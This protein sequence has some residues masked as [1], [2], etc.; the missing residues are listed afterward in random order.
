MEFVTLEE[1]EFDVFAKCQ[2]H[3]NFWQSVDM[4]KLRQKNG[5][6]I[7]YIGVKEKQ[8][9]VAGAM[10]SYRNIFLHYMRVE[11]LRGAYLDYE[12]EHM[13]R[14][15]YQHMITYAKKLH[16]LYITV[17][18]YL[19]LQERDMFGKL[20]IDGFD[21]HNIINI[22]ASLG[23]C[24]RPSF[25]GNDT[26]KEPGWMFVREI[27]E[28][29]EDVLFASLDHQTR[30]SIRKTMKIGI[31][32]E[33]GTHDDVERF[34]KI[35][36]HTA[37]RRSFED[38]GFSYYQQLW[39][40]FGASHHMK[41]LFAKL[42][43]DDYQN[44]I[45][46]ELLQQQEALSTIEAVLQKQ[47]SSRKYN[48]RKKACFEQI[49]V[50]EKQ[51]IEANELQKQGLSIDLAAAIFITTGKEIVYLYSGAY[52]EYLKFNGPYAL[53][54]Y[55]FR[56]AIKNGYLRY[57]F[58]GI[59]G[60]FEKDAQDYGVYEFKRGF[61]GHVEELIGEFTY[62]V[63]PKTYHIYQKLRKLKQNLL[64]HTP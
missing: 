28:H 30:W 63:R 12:N 34:H 25:I 11:I 10:V 49:Q 40:T 26:K 61:G 38:R 24:Y 9:I 7:A 62:I 32:V 60:N 20:V 6:K 54:W 23:Y 8:K 46:K 48:K 21:H 36:Q 58:Y 55:M 2:S 52:K 3:Q 33:E 27:K 35:M 59:S 44:R 39:N 4:A 41:M 51:Y 14:Y 45:T 56:Y 53:Q 29:T 43:V 64:K 13:I 37:K 47:P 1:Q 50:L 17:N 42:D 15:F 57:N 5:W 18:P 31:Q 22:M 19:P 16:A